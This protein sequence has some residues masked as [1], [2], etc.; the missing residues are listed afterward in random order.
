MSLWVCIRGS[1]TSTCNM[2]CTTNLAKALKK[3][4]LNLL[5]FCRRRV[6]MKCFQR[7]KYVGP[8]SAAGKITG[9]RTWV[10]SHSLPLNARPLFFCSLSPAPSL[11][12]IILVES[13]D[14]FDMKSLCSNST[15][16]LPI[17][18]FLFFLLHSV[19]NVLLSASTSSVSALLSPAPVFSS[20]IYTFSWS[21]V[22]MWVNTHL[23][24]F[25]NCP[26]HVYL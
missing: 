14:L 21:S 1:T 8:R 6:I 19:L 18:L 13:S 17:C 9:I 4:H 20:H 16:C 26:R 5:L 22:F 12:S 2:T 25:S 10:R 24:H 3:Q 11:S 15:V 7:Q 23:L